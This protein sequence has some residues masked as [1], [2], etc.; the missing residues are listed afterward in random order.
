MPPKDSTNFSIAKECADAKDARIAALEARADL[1]ESLL[2]EVL[3]AWHADAS[4]RASRIV[5]RAVA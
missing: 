4:N 5:V 1:F 3:A 2:D